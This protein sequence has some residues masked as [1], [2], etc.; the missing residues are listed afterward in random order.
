MQAPVS[1]IVCTHNPRPDYLSR[2]LLSL[3]GQTL[4]TKQWEFLLVDNASRQPLAKAWDISWHLRGRHVRE[5]EL[6]LTSA[7]LRGIQECSGELL[8]FVDDDNVLA[9]D[10]LERA[11]AIA[12]RCPGLGVFGA[13]ILQPEFEVQPPVELHSLLKLLALRSEPS[14]LWSN[15]TK[16]ADSIPWGAGLCVARRV[17]N[18]YRQLVLDLGIAAVL[19]RRGQRLYSGGDELFSWAAAGVDLGFGVF[20]ELQITHLISAGRLNKSYL[21][22]FIR[23]HAFSY[24]ILNYMVRGIKPARIDL[25]GYG[26]LL[27]HAMKNGQFSMR[28]QWARWRGAED[29]A[30]FISE[31]H[32]EPLGRAL[33][34]NGK[35]FETS[36][37][38]G[39][40]S[41]TPIVEGAVRDTAEVENR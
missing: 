18:F 33:S 22:R 15:N 29:A 17:A 39:P 7:R 8:V 37:A 21:L 9:A 16:D 3:R 36:F 13:G 10:F 1:V 38:C 35:Q 5:D 30:Q 25:F 31:R 4:P 20:P 32:L 28:C 2:V 6:G 14:A 19:D 11:T 24:R 12:A 26:H 34:G 23:D 40:A 41:T 27:L